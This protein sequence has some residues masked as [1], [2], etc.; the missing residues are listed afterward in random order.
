[1]CSW[2]E[3]ERFLVSVRILARNA[4][5]LLDEHLSTNEHLFCVD[6]VVDS[7]EEHGKLVRASNQRQLELNLLLHQGKELLVCKRKFQIRISLHQ[8]NHSQKQ[9]SCLHQSV[10][11]T[12]I[13]YVTLQFAVGFLLECSEV[14]HHGRAKRQHLQQHVG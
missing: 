11:L 4:L 6:H 5:R 10:H 12:G 9:G 14:I 7:I 3:G 13:D 8:F 1:M 2:L